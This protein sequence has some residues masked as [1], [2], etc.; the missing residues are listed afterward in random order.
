MKFDSFTV[1]AQSCGGQD[2]SAPRTA[3]VLAP[4]SPDG[5]GGY[6]KSDVKVTLTATDND[7]GSG[8]DHTEYR[9]AGAAN[10]TAYSAPFNV[11]TD[12]TQHDRV[13]LGRQE[14]QR[15]VDPVGHHQARQDRSDDDRQ[16]QR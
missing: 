9:A 8:V 4:A 10:W 1:E 7:G 3:H 2:T 14:G 11:T 16:A 6:Y 15:R 5:D 13:P 12:G